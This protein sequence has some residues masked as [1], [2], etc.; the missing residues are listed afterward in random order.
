[1]LELFGVN[2]Y[3]GHIRA[4]SDVSL[5]I[6]EGEIITLI[7]ANGAGK[8]TTLMTISGLT[9]ARSGRILFENKPIEALNPEKIVRHGVCH[10]PEGRRIFPFLTV[11]ENLDMGAY[12]RK[13]KAGIK[14]DLSWVFD[15]FPILEKRKHQAGGTLSG[16]EQQMLAISR[17]LMARPRL[18]LLDEPSLGLAPLIIRQIFDIIEK[19]N[20]EHNTTIFLV[21]QNAN[22]ALTMAHRAY[23]MENGRITLSGSGRELLDNDAV[24]TAYLGI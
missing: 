1:M 22:L 2:T 3:Y 14:K 20:R 24:K 13:D 21:E 4:L 10:V 18:L 5:T 23:V 12:L 11:L 15:L 19:L 7:G 8:T 17:A 6:D 9:P 16:G